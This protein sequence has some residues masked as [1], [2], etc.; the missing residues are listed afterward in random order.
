MNHGGWYACIS[1]NTKQEVEKK[2]ECKHLGVRQILNANHN[3]FFLFL[4]RGARDG[5][6]GLT[7]IRQ[8]LCL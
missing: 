2:Q 3:F 6:Q 7:H 4:F 8:A 1:T 5:I